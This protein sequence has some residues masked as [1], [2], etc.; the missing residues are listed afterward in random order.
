[1]SASET[2]P[3]K[4]VLVGCG[5]MGRNQAKILAK[6]DEFELVGVT[7][8]DPANAAR[9]AEAT[10]AKVYA[11][12][13]GMLAAEKPDTVT[14]CTCND[15]HAALTIAA[16]QSGVRGVYCE[17]P[18]ATTLAD[19]RA[20][21]VA[22]R[23]AGIP[24]VINHQRRIGADLLTARRLIEDGAIG[25]VR[26]IRG[27]CAGDILSDGTHLIDSIL[28]LAGDASVQ[29]VFG[30]V[31]RDLAVMAAKNTKMKRADEPG[32]R[33]GH[34]VESGGTAVIQLEGDVRVE[35]CTGDLR[36]GRRAY[37]DYEVFGDAG[38]LW[39]T[40]DRHKPNLFIQDAEGGTWTAGLDEWTYKPVPTNGGA[41]GAWR[42][43]EIPE[44]M[45]TAGI[46]GGYE[47]FARMI[48]EGEE[49]PMS[50]ETAL[51]GH[52]IVMAIYESA[53]L[54]RRIDLPLEQGRFPLE[55]MIEAGVF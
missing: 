40:G 43:V 47:R 10:G 16:A 4:T 39:R 45:P 18:M 17:K 20:M 42:P 41:L 46:P 49:H 30:Q 26:L 1:M 32:T 5:S 51:R 6:L 27:N 35:L 55:L 19:A 48:H 34:V 9:A 37:Q 54:H 3:L 52:E 31:H 28:W 33:Y 50:G 8:I 7:D 38:R 36:D 13:A 15:T 23:E 25:E 21:V 12:F 22:C 2:T 53:R 29:W 24:L 44:N 14:V 11:D